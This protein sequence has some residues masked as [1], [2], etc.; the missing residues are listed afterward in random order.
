MYTVEFTEEILVITSSLNS[1]EDTQPIRVNCSITDLGE[2]RSGF[3]VKCYSLLDH[4]RSS[5]FLFLLAS[6]PLTRAR[7][8]PS[9]RVRFMNKSEVSHFKCCPWFPC[10]QWA[11]KQ[12]S[13]TS[14][15]WQTAMIPNLHPASF[16]EL[17]GPPHFFSCKFSPFRQFWP[18]LQQ[19]SFSIPGPSAGPRGSS[20]KLNTTEM[21]L[22]LE[23]CHPLHN[24]SLA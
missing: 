4:A 16:Q 8:K 23:K 3:E 19:F 9:A 22:C 2:R 12:A 21:F 11:L 14:N 20:W 13:M 24:K 18:S 15:F 10:W 6:V 7:T 17:N 5:L 1:S